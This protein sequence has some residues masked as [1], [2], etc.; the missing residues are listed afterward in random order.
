MEVRL[1]R[2]IPIFAVLTAPT[3]EGI[4]RELEQVSIPSGTTLVPRG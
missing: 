1:L 4:A 3:I 2:A